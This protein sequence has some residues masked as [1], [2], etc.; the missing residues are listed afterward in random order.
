[1]MNPS[2]FRNRGRS[3]F[4]LIEAVIVIT[5]TGIIGAVVAIFISAPVKAYFDVARRAEITDVADGAVRRI[6]RDIHLALPNSVRVTD[7]N[8]TIEFL[9][10]HTGGRYRIEK[11]VGTDDPL[12]FDA[13]DTSFDVLGSVSD[14]VQNVDQIV[15]YNLGISG[16]DAYV[17]DNRVT[18]T[19]TSGTV[20]NITFGAKQFPFDSPG[21]NFHVVS[22]AVTYRY[23]TV[24]RTL[25]RY[26]GY[27]ITSGTPTLSGAA[28]IATN[29]TDCVFTYD[30]GLTQRS[31]L[32]TMRISIASTSTTGGGTETVSLY[33]AVHVNNAP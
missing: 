10:T 27:T 30:A 24:A 22:G 5:L 16:A 25:T 26:S 9:L 2:I 18:Y 19:G 7:S 13:T 32:V 12:D 8:H 6:A 20:S 31:G 4:T 33:H 15:I 3:G 1:M 14:M 17:G 11:G 21:H 29:V 23:D 28:V